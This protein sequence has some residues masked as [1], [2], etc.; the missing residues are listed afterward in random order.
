MLDRRE[1]KSCDT[2]G[3]ELAHRDSPIPIMK[4]VDTKFLLE[5]QRIRKPDLQKY[6]QIDQKAQRAEQVKEKREREKKEKEELER[7]RIEVAAAKKDVPDT[8]CENK[9]DSDQY[10]DRKLDSVLDPSELAEGKD[11]DGS[12]ES[13]VNTSR[14]DKSD[15][16]NKNAGN[17]GKKEGDVLGENLRNPL[18]GGTGSST[19]KA[20]TADVEGSGRG[21]KNSPRRIKNGSQGGNKSN[22]GSKASNNKV[23]ETISAVYDPLKKTSK[24]K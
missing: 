24:P 2:G 18:T 21:R 3:F 9:K 6:M 4:C 10:S 23:L 5:G 19:K 7:V 12:D 16:E 11:K 14:S 1:N 17:R 20:S 13:A 15:K 8:D 22:T